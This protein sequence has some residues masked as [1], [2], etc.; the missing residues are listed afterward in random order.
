MFVS[1]P[2]QMQALD[3]VE[4]S[5]MQLRATISVGSCGVDDP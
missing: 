1:G 2:V 3:R 4:K 5:L